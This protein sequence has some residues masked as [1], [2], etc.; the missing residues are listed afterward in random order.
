M[1]N[2]FSTFVQIYDDILNISIPLNMLGLGTVV[3]KIRKIKDQKINK[4][5]SKL[6]IWMLA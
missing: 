6:S 3:W 4:T 5:Y 2:A 1:S